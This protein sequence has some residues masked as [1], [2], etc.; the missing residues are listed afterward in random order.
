MGKYLARYN[1]TVKIFHLDMTPHAC[2]WACRRTSQTAVPRWTLVLNEPNGARRGERP[3]TYV[4]VMALF[5]WPVCFCSS[6]SVQ[7]PSAVYGSL[8]SPI[9]PMRAVVPADI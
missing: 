4:V 1:W 5:Y 9:V 7:S 3:R 8:G 2:S 6:R